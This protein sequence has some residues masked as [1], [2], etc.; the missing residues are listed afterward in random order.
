MSLNPTNPTLDDLQFGPTGNR[1]I[2]VFPH[3]DT[4]FRAAVAD[5]LAAIAQWDGPDLL[6]A[7][8]RSEYPAVH[9]VE[10]TALGTSFDEP[11]IYVFRDGSLSPQ[12]GD[13]P[14][15][16]RYLGPLVM[17]Q[18]TIARSLAL[19]QRSIALIVASIDAV[20]R[21]R[22]HRSTLRERTAVR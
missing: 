8:L 17:P 14:G 12:L 13:G 16:P 7:A 6:E 5:A 15:S 9:V 2:R 19:R 1:R 4:A 22:Q 10:Q 21:S 20:Q 3:S 18:R 11:C